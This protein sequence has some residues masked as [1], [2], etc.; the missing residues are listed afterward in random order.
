M[1]K[2]KQSL[3]LG[4]IPRRKDIESYVYGYTLP[5]KCGKISQ[6]TDWITNPK[7]M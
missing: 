5:P 7:K 3:S 1:E 6:F 4:T 2:F